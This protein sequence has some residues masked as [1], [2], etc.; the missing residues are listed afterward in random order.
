MT[1]NAGGVESQNQALLCC[2]M[3]DLPPTQVVIPI[4]GSVSKIIVQNSQSSRYLL[5]GSH[6]PLQKRTYQTSQSD[7]P[8]V[9]NIRQSCFLRDELLEGKLQYQTLPKVSVRASKDSISPKLSQRQPNIPRPNPRHTPIKETHATNRPLYD[10]RYEYSVRVNGLSRIK[11]RE[12]SRPKPIQNATYHN[13]EVIHEQHS[14]T[15]NTSARASSPLEK[16]QT[17]PHRPLHRPTQKVTTHRHPKSPRSL[18]APRDVIISRRTRPIP[19]SILRKPPPLPILRIAIF[20]FGRLFDH[21]Q[22]PYPTIMQIDCSRLPPPPRHLCDRFTGL[23]PVIATDFFSH[24]INVA[25]YESALDVLRSSIDNAR[26]DGVEH[27]A[28]LVGCRIGVHRSVAMAEAMRKRVLGWEGVE[29]RVEHLDL[30]RE[31]RRRMR[32]RERR[33][34]TVEV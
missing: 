18:P 32:M 27:V 24:D 1:I 2:K 31:L 9:K 5:L 4:A 20:T 34:R 7:S 8:E 25:L 14:N 23:D 22:P 28:V 17:R 30:G 10:Q 3:A 15:P 26:H 16:I 12:F 33:V 6:V 19:V 29:V 21:P 11:S 13:L